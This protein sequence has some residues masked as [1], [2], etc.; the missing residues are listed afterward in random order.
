L[1]TRHPRRALACALGLL[2]L[3]TACG[4]GRSSTPG[5]GAYVALGASDTVGIGATRPTQDGWV[6]LLAVALPE[7][8]PVVNL[9]V[10]G[11]TLA[12]VIAGQLPIAADAAP[13]WLTLWPGPND[14]RAGVALDTFTDQLDRILATLRP[15]AGT[16]RTMLILD[17]PDLRALPA[18][19]RI[20][21]A[22]LDRQVRAWNAAIA[23]TVAR[24]ADYAVLVDLYD[25]WEEL[26]ANPQY[27]SGDG[28]HP[29]N[30]GYRRIADL[31][32][33]TLRAHDPTTFR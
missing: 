21:P 4:P 29:S 12:D 27:I 25:G 5:A 2:L 30:A 20:D 28:F 6:P 26:A 17:L 14:L 15:P 3:L 1:A 31:A 8:T 13:R 16:S 9:G 23:S 7:G 22:Q 11:A 24:Y 10:S 19:A 32:L 33:A 18:F